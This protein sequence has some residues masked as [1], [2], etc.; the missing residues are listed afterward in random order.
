[1]KRIAFLLVTCSMESTRAEALEKVVQNL[2]DQVPQDILDRIVVFDNASKYPGTI[3]LLCA[4]FSIVHRADHNVGYWTAVDW[5]LR[6]QVPNPPQYTYIIESDTI[7]WDFHRLTH[8]ADYLDTHAE[9]GS[10]RVHEYSVANNHLYDKGRPHAT[11][12]RSIWQS[13]YNG[14]EKKQ[15]HLTLSDENSR[16]YITNFLAMLPSLNRYDAMINVFNRLRTLKKFAESDFQAIYH[17]FHKLNAILDGGIVNGDLCGS[18]TNAIAGS[19]ITDAHVKS[20]GYQNVRQSSIL[21]DDSYNVVR[22]K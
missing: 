22:I 8:C 14:V 17:E 12:R 1:M 11:S 3:D 10:V 9:I 16:I 6:Q 2:H 18:D 5:W 15:V 19:R 4:N 20:I 21:S 7:H 13:H